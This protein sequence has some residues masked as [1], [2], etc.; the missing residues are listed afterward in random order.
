MTLK[1]MTPNTTA[2]QLAAY[3]P[4]DGTYDDLVDDGG[5]RPHWAKVARSL[6][7]LGPL[8]L[9]RRSAET[10][11]LLLE[12][13]VT[14]NATTPTGTAT[15]PWVLDP[16]PVVVSPDEWAR[17]EAGLAQR[18]ELFD[19]VLADLYGSRRLIG[20][21]LLPPEVVYGHAG[22]LRQC[23]QI[24]LR[25]E[26]QLFHAAFDLARDRD[27]SWVVLSDR[28]QA[29]SG[30]GYALEN[31]L[32][33]ARVLP[34]L[35]RDAEVVRLAA[36]FRALRAALQRVAPEA[37]EVP[38]I[39]V[40]TPGPW[41][42]TAY[43]HG[44]LASYLGYPLVQGTDLRVRDGRVWERTLGR[45]EPV[46]V[47][48]RRV[49]ASWCDPLELRPES[50]LGAPGLIEACRTGNVSVV[51]TLGSGVLENPALL[52]FLPSLAEVLLGQELHLPSATTW[53]CGEPRPR[54]H[55]L[56]NLDRLVLKSATG[57]VSQTIV[58]AE[59]AAAELDD[60]RRRIEAEPHAWVGQEPV[61]LGSTPTLNEGTLEARRS[62]L[63]GYVVSTE[64]GYAV[65]P[66]GLTRVAASRDEVLITNQNGAWSKDTWVLSGEPE[67]LTGFWLQL[68]PPAAVPE[69][70][71]SQRAAENLFWL[72]RYA[73][74]AE[75]LVRQIRVVAD[76]LVEFAPGTNPAG[77]TCLEVLLT[78]LTRTSGSFPGFVGSG[79]EDRL[80]EPI[81]ELRDLLIDRD[82]Q[83][84]VAHSVHRMLNAAAQVRDQLSNDTWLVIG[85]LE[86]DLAALDH[87]APLSADTRALGRVMAAMLAL[88][89]LSAE[90]MVRDD[91]WQFMEAGRRLERALQVCTLLAA[92]VATVRD[93]ATDSLIVES[94]LTSAESIVTYRRRYRSHATLATMLDLMVLD[95]TNPRS[96]RY[97]VGAL[98]E[99]VAAM[100]Q[101]EA[102]AQV[103]IDI[104]VEE[105][106][107]AVAL[108][109]TDE[110]ARGADAPE[111]DGAS[112]GPDLPVAAF[113]AHVAGLLNQLGERIDAAHFS[114]QL[115]QRAVAQSQPFASFTPQ[116]R[117]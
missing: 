64:D 72:S 74:R 105:L 53:W 25:G 11:R 112:A 79:G 102:S 15:R 17:L 91:G 114:H 62:V 51:N 87:S 85:H 50:T 106:G 22:F 60:L 28:T 44:A 58:G 83:G 38:R 80:A 103:E 10:R 97:Q 29:P 8:E 88:S 12:D 2:D 48:L 98:A 42:E 92:T 52:A 6:G 78:A 3:R 116:E 100:P 67:R 9:V 37:A 32:V 75:D 115:P 76:R 55:V 86:R 24:R 63:R 4:I 35:Y 113:L 99:A 1:P 69:T 68:E 23:D 70:A 14:Y 96:L 81:A 73:E 56:A 7:E 54:S 45:L 18:A 111:R 30:M 47:I 49:D 95:P 31:R 36:F 107:T 5:V 43:E 26:R 110:L 66:G 77:N 20:D 89:G 21:G 104:L 109:D 46:H 27:G 101:P 71:M 82:R 13:G 90:S 39:V 108:A 65:M 34:E 19:L 93:A 61:E 40:L 117:S 84:T 57:Q 59:L 94:V 41:S 16:V 33:L